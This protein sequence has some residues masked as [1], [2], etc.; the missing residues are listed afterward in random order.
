MFEKAL[1]VWKRH[2]PNARATSEPDLPLVGRRVLIIVENLPVPFDRRVWQE[3]KTLRD[4]GA[5]VAVICPTGNGHQQRYEF[6]DGVHI[7]RH[8]LPLEA[9]S[10]LGY[11][12]EY[13][14][15]L[16]WETYLAWMIFFKHGFDVIHACNPPDLIFLVA[17]PFKLLGKKFIFDHHDINPELYEAKFGRRDMFWRLL[18]ALERLTF[19]LAD[20]SIATNNSYREIAMSRNSMAHEKVFVVRSGPDLTLLNPVAPNPAWKNGRRFLVGYV[21]VMG[22]QEGIDLLL[23]AALHIVRSLGRE[24]IQFCLVGNGPSYAKI[25]VAAAQMQL[26]DYVTFLGRLP[27]KEMFEVLCTSDVCVNC[28]RVNQMNN[29]STM[30][31]ILEYMAMARPIVQFDMKE[32]RLS[33]GAASLYARANDPVDFA[34][35]IIDLLGDENVRLVMGQIGRAR[36]ESELSWQRQSF[37]LVEAYSY[38]FSESRRLVRKEAVGPRYQ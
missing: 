18:I 5:H 31:K 12:S 32:G 37:R 35:K 22:E 8:P 20:A 6:I 7:Y 26:Q 21:G 14:A 2:S 16:A 29:L 33:A 25:K 24:D 15:A 38:V 4:A 19:K 1:T 3:A 30:N 10:P 13:G 36:I 23:E 9:S 28:D 17:L 11:L 34:T 27:D